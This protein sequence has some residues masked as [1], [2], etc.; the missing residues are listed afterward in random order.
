[1]GDV[2]TV[3]ERNLHQQH[4]ADAHHIG[5]LDDDQT[6]RNVPKLVLPW[7]GEKYHEEDPMQPLF[8]AGTLGGNDDTRPTA[9]VVHSGNHSFG[10]DRDDVNVQNAVEHPARLAEDQID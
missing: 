8:E 5:P 9:F 4:A 2:E 1:M 3:G 10:A 6:G 7:A